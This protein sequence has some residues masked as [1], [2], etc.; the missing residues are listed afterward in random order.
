MSY[1]QWSNF[2]YYQLGDI[3]TLGS[4]DYQALQPNI[5][6]LPSLLAP[7]WQL[8]PSPSGSGVSSLSTLTGAIT[9]SCSSGT[10]TTVGN[11]IALAITFPTP[12]GVSSLSSLT[13]AIT[14]SCSTGTYT[15]VGNNIALA[16]NFPISSINGLTGN[17]S[18]LNLG[19]ST[20]EVLTISP[21]IQVGLNTNAFGTYT[22]T[23]GGSAVTNITAN[24][25]VPTSVVQ[26]T[27]IHTG[28]GGGAQYIQ[29]IIP[30]A[31]SFQLRTN[32]VVDINDKI[33]WI[34]LNP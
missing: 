9:Q 32:T 2:V 17:P 20:I 25:C 1:S 7:N 21:D 15:T 19:R 23:T 11:D 3:A 16:I 8:L 30:S 14:Q 4:I 34:V 33:N 26:I 12:T 27:Y 10:Y 24:A 5:N 6:V 28:G 13:G 29:D 18:I 31:G 22:E